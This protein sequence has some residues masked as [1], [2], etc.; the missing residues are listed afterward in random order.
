MKKQIFLTVQLALCSAF[1]SLA[2]DMMVV[3]MND[4][5]DCNISIDNIAK[6]TIREIE[7]IPNVHLSC[8]DD[9]HPHLIDIGLPSGTK[10]KCCNE[11]AYEP[12]DDGKY[13]AWGEKKEKKTY[14]WNV[15]QHCDGSRW[16]CHYIGDDIA[17]TEYD[18]WGGWYYC[19]PSESLFMELLNY[20]TQKWVKY[21]GKNGML[22]TGPNGSSIFLPAA[23]CRHRINFSDYFRVDFERGKGALGFYWSSSL[24][25]NYDYSAFGLN[26]NSNGCGYFYYFRCDGFPIRC[27]GL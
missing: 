10:W 8:P 19:M 13:Y 3:K 14:S 5:S 22:F 21:N 2:Q 6:V 27:V 17:G 7:E 24:S 16:S 9:R 20:C 12:E 15:Y 26:F 4:D 1:L 23:G 11:G 25:P 18:V